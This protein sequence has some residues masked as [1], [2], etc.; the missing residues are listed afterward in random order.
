MLCVTRF[1]NQTYNEYR[2]WCNKHEFTGCIYG[3][4]IKMGNLIESDSVLFV[5]EM[6][7]STNKIVG[8]GMLPSKN[9]ICQKRHKIYSDNNYNRYTYYS[10]Y[11]ID[12]RYNYLPLILFKKISMLEKLIFY[13]KRHCKRGQ[14]IQ[15]IPQW[16]YS[17][18]NINID[19][20]ID[21]IKITFKIY[22]S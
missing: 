5:L 19:S 7:N 3:T 2:T 20:I 15:N 12:L 22:N 18:K 14:G 9:N 6:N 17:L 11:R 13:G 4:P 8:I 21:I 16:I 10:K 1:N